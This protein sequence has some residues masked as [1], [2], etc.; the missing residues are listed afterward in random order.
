MLLKEAGAFVELLHWVDTVE[1][2]SDHTRHVVDRA[3]D[4]SQ[5]VQAIRAEEWTAEPLIHTPRGNGLVGGR[6]EK[7]LRQAGNFAYQIL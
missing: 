3:V 6:G 2:F 1:A 7:L 4:G 5:W